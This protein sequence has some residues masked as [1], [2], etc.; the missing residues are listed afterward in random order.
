[1]AIQN[2]DRR[3]TA[4]TSQGPRSP[5]VSII[6]VSYNTCEMTCECLRSIARET[7]GLAHEVIVVDNASADGS[8]EAIAEQFPGVR[9]I[10]L[11]DNIGFAAANN[12]AAGEARGSFLLLL[13]PDTVVLDH[14]I[15]KL[16]RFARCCPDA[17]IWG[18]RTVFADGSLNAASCWRRI[19]LWNLF[20]RVSGLTAMFRNSDLF[21]GEAYGGWRRDTV[22]RVDI[23]TGCFF[24]ITRRMWTD[25]GGF[26]R[27]FFMYGEEA[28][29]CLRAA[30]RGAAPL[31]TP[32]AT[33]IHYGG[34]SE[35]VRA[36]KMVKLLS[37][38]SL[39][40]QRH[41]PSA[42]RSLG[43][44][45]NAAWPLTRTLAMMMLAAATGRPEHRRAAGDWQ[46]I[47]LRRREWFGGYDVRSGGAGKLRETALGSAS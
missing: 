8:A 3:A 41:F 11:D 47:W 16:V 22:R 14:A 1:M 44:M 24:L 43:L 4:S 32:E 26:D 13:N 19:S 36:D 25:L 40:I 9:L 2:A 18:G 17:G 15:E 39:L 6:V 27:S 46:A 34:A 5:V 29:L 30:A 45:L 23:V 31:V 38:R 28:D 35:T 33:I 7:T 37:A 21:N 20:C 42:T 12:L 10:A